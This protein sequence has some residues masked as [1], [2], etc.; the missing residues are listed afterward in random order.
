ML[1]FQGRYEEAVAKAQQAIAANR[2][3]PAGYEALGKALIFAGEPSRSLD[4]LRTAV[5]LDPQHAYNYQHWSGL[6]QYGLEE[7]EQS[8]RSLADASQRNPDDERILIPLAA[9]YG[10]LGRQEEGRRAVARLNDAR[11]LQNERLARSGLTPG[12]D[13]FLFGP[14]TLQDL[15]LWPFKE[16]ADRQRLR[17]GLERVGVPASGQADQESPKQI[18]GAVTIDVTEARALFDRGVKF[19]DVRGPSWDLGHI[20]GAVHLFL[21]EQFSEAA[22]AEVTQKDEEIVFYCMVPNCLLSSKACARAVSWGYENVYYLRDGFPA[23]QAAGHPVE[24]P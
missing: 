15:D 8:A 11:R 5:R 21:K 2:N 24:I 18:A 23:W 14:L 17:D 4:P 13:L 7:F 20:P 9:A 19:V 6:A 12:I 3:D 22:L 16:E 10:M 1:V